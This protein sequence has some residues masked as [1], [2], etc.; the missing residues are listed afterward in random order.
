[1][2]GSASRT[3]PYPLKDRDKSQ[4]HDMTR[5]ESYHLCE[6]CTAIFTSYRP[7]NDANSVFPHDTENNALAQAEDID[8]YVC[9][10]LW[11]E[12]PFSWQKRKLDV[13]N[14]LLHF[15][16]WFFRMRRRRMAFRLILSGPLYFQMVFLLVGTAGMS[17]LS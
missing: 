8:C 3:D 10:R 11:T 5:A 2:T 15:K 4:P 17:R 13:H 9:V 14:S 6:T 12:R 7:G 1:M 16:Y